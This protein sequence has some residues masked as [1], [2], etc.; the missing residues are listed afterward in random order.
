M[1]QTAIA[2]KNVPTPKVVAKVI[3]KTKTRLSSMATP[4]GFS[5][6]TQRVI[7]EVTFV[8][9]IVSVIIQWK[10]LNVITVNVIIRF[11][12]SLL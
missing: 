10:P 1:L 11:M 5:S 6:A 12:L 4:P 2:N 7:R 3:E 9:S 8:P